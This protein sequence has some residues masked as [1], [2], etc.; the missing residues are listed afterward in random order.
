MKVPVKNLLVLILTSVI[1]ASAAIAQ[2]APQLFKDTREKGSA[3]ARQNIEPTVTRSRTVSVNESILKDDRVS[4]IT[5]PLF[6]GRSVRLDKTSALPD[7]SGTFIW[8]GTYDDADGNVGSA[9]IVSRGK[10]VVG[11]ITTPQGK[12][13]QIRYLG[14]EVH[15]LREI[16]QSQFPDEIEAYVPG[17]RALQDLIPEAP[18][19]TCTTDPPG[20]IDM[21][22]VYD[23]AARNGAGGTDGIIA[24]VYL[25]LQETNQSYINSAVNHRVRI[26]HIAEVNYTEGGNF[27]TYLTDLQSTNGIIDQVQGLRNTYGAD[28]VSMIVETGNACGIGYLMNTLS[29]AFEPWAYSVTR[30]DCAT[31]Y[32]SFGH[33]LGHNLTANHDPA[34]AGAGSIYAYA[35]GHFN[36]APTFPATPWRTVMTYQTSPASTRV[37]YWSNPNINYPVGGNPMGIVNARDN[38]RAM[39]NT[40]PVAV[41][42]RCSSPG[43]NDVWMKDTWKDRGVEPDPL[44]ASDAMWVSPYIWN[45]TTIDTNLTQQH[46]HQNPEWG[47]TNYVYVKV[48]NGA[49]VPRTGNL[50]LRFAHAATGLSW[51]GAWIPVSGSPV[52]V[53]I[54][55]KTSIVVQVPWNN[56]PINA[57]PHY[58]MIARWVSGTDP[59]TFAET[60]DINYNTRQNNNIVWRNMNV[61]NLIPPRG[62]TT[63]GE[64]TAEF[65]FR[66]L[67]ENRGARLGLGFGPVETADSAFFRN[68]GQVE[69]TFDGEMFEAVRKGY[70]D[71]EG[72][73]LN[74]NTFIVTGLK[75]VM[76]DGI[77][78]P[79]KFESKVKVRFV[80]RGG[81]PEFAHQLE[82]V[83]YELSQTGD[84]R[85]AVGGVRYQ[86]TNIPE[87]G[88]GG[89]GGDDDRGSFLFKGIFKK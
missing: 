19:D 87:T 28:V 86:V 73:K 30:R 61:V 23:V 11:N 37:P 77:D 60:T 5:V 10:A 26:V 89:G 51:P 84:K 54:P 16:D 29:N 80:M 78:V 12:M 68:G 44:Q 6:D 53:T 48:H 59:M 32:Y 25:A 81:G 76:F 83:Q 3:S 22:I 63:I 52:A 15:S 85:S 67:K 56:V 65:I 45:R 14:E 27:S 82:A 13:F 36:T 66:N 41:N 50:D 40:A 58:C 35:R 69:I 2:Q 75:G 46:R 34:N 47:Q 38:A 4:A 21:L 55:A 74:G 31:G 42:F 9:I 72:V 62:D 1:T 7:E 20:V 43:R 71:Q 39:N 70:K 17:M 18:Q 64:E 88:T 57:N 79:P 24:T 33:E 8:K 49:S